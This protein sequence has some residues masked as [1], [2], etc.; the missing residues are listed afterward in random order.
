MNIGLGL[1]PS[2]RLNWEQQRQLAQEAVG[3]G[4]TSLW[5]PSSINGRDAFHIC[6]QWWGATAQATPGGLSTGISVV[7]A[8]QWTATTLAA[9]AGTVAEIT[10]GRFV[11]GIGTG[12]IYSADYRHTYGMAELPPLAVMKDYLTTLR[13]LLSGQAVEHEGP[14]VTLHGLRLT[15]RPPAVPVYLAALGP[16]MLRLA[17]AAADGASLNWCSAEQVA[18][19]REVIAQGAARVNRDAAGV[20]VQEYIRICVDDDQE[21]ARISLAKSILSYALARAGASKEH[22]YRG[23]FARMGFDAQLSALEARRDAG[24]TD[25]EIAEAFPTELLRHVA[26]YGPAAGADAAFRRLAQG[27]DTAVVRVVAARPGTDSVRAVMQ[28]C[29]PALSPVS[30]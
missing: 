27:L 12:S 22:G 14:A 1:D 8:P 29:A 30:H 19:S 21:V 25:D 4:Y 7:P 20:H 11:L 10:G 13:G 15:F 6:A 24:A 28:A 26:Y 16:Q 9:T 5:S 23:H 3:L 17:G 18:W 2:L